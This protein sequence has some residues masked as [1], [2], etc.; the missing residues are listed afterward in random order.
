VC[1]GDAVIRAVAGWLL[2]AVCLVLMVVVFVP[3]WL[4]EG[5]VFVWR[6]LTRGEG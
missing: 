3:V 1:V 2:S 6:E 5:A 4:C